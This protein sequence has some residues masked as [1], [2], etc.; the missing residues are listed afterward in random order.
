M[1]WK[2]I[3]QQISFKLKKIDNLEKD[4]LNLLNNISANSSII[5]STIEWNKAVSEWMNI[6]LFVWLFYHKNKLI[7]YIPLFRKKLIVDIFF[8]PFPWSESAYSEIVIN[9]N[10]SKTKNLFYDLL[11]KDCSN[12]FINLSPNIDYKSRYYSKWKTIFM[13]LESIDDKQL[14]KNMR[15]G[16][17][18]AIKASIKKNLEFIQIYSETDKQYFYDII[19]ETYINS[20]ISIL[21]FSFYNLLWNKLNDYIE[22]FLIK[23]NWTTVACIWSIK[24]KNQLN[25]WLWWSKKSKEILALNANQFAQWNILLLNL[26]KSNKYDMLWANNE[27]IARYKKWFWG[28]VR[29]YNIIYWNIYIY[30]IF[31]IYW[32]LW[33]KIKNFIRIFIRNN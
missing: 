21:P 32:I 2:E 6:I 22:L 33:T 1:F 28:E 25:Y 23:K 19:K 18:S 10:Y 29:S 3:T 5:F 27:K 9:S 17:K 8:S 4:E 20:N 14:L 24:F 13:N 11:L 16:H 7:W 12:T 31:K 30:L 15:K 26:N